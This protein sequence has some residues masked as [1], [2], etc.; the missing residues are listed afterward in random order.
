MHL[1]SQIKTIKNKIKYQYLDNDNYK[2]IKYFI[3]IKKTKNK[4]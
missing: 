1:F 2:I 4:T 3:K